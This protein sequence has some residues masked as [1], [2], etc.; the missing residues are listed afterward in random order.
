[1]ST[2]TG[3]RLHSAFNKHATGIRRMRAKRRCMVHDA[4][5]SQIKLKFFLLGRVDGIC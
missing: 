3:R 2:P 4:E 5:K 1:M